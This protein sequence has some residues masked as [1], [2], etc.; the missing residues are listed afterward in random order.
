[1]GV[2]LEWAILSK[3]LRLRFDILMSGDEDKKNENN[4][5]LLSF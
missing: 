4:V 3:I 5:M 1:M 2:V